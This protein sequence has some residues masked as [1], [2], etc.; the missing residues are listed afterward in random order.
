[1]IQLSA[2]S[3]TTVAKLTRRYLLMGNAAFLILTHNDTSKATSAWADGRLKAR[4]G[5]AAQAWEA[6]P[7][8]HDIRLGANRDGLFYVPPDLQ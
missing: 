7:G 4:T 8:T 3:R 1:M 6:G 5:V 2:K